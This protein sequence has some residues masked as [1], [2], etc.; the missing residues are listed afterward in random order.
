MR[1][2]N[3]WTVILILLIAALS[4]AAC[5]EAAT[6]TPDK[7]E[8]AHVEPI[9]GTELNRVV[10]AQKAAERLG[11]ET[12][13]VREEQFVLDRS[14]EGKV[15]AAPETGGGNP[16]R[17]W[18]RISLPESERTQV[19]RSRPVRILLLGDDVEDDDTEGWTAEPDEGPDVDDS[20]D[21]GLTGEDVAEA[22]YYRIANV[23]HNLAPGQQ[24]LVEFAL[25]D[26]AAQ[27][28][29]VPY[30][31][32]IYG[33]NGEAWVYVSPEPL[34]YHREPVTIDYIEGDTAVL[35][36]GPPVGTEVVTVGVAELYGTDTGVG[37]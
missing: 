35:V 8:P 26:D 4:L 12:A 3:Q 10:L 30:A 36:D 14:V 23:E 19:D 34:T 37:K 27:R 20:E 5:S 32:V 29:V 7:S 6:D 24:V 31:A 9:E 15:V 1:R 13:F 17:V 16:D 33:L 18:V 22:L 11:I 21:A 28:T 2:S 25:L